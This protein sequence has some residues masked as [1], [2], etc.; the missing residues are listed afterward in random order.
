MPSLI[1]CAPDPLAAVSRLVAARPALAAYLAGRRWPSD[2][3]AFLAPP[4]RDAAAGHLR[5]GRRAR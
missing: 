3:E 5:A 4:I 1:T 2:F